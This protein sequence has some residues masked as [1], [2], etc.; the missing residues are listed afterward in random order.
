LGDWETAFRVAV[1][2]LFTVQELETTAEGLRSGTLAS[3]EAGGQLLGAKVVIA[4]AAQALD[5]TRL[6]TA[7]RD[8]LRANLR[9]VFDVIDRWQAGEV[10]SATA[11]PELAAL[12][13][14]AEQVLSELA[15]EMRRLGVS[16]A[17]ID[18]LMAELDK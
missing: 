13:A 11:G 10:S 7:L 2:S 9:G 17:R 18:A 1:I 15:D 5:E 16:Q 12:R 6:P 3:I 14:D 8:R 4:A